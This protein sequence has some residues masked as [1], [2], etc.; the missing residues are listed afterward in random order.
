VAG[1][2][3]GHRLG[4]RGAAARQSQRDPDGH[5]TA[6]V[7]GD[8]GAVGAPHGAVF[9][10]AGWPA[11]ASTG[12]SASTTSAAAMGPLVLDPIPSPIV[13]GGTKT[14]SGT[15][16]TPASVIIAF[17]Q[18]G[19]GVQSLGPY[20]PTSETPTQ[21][22]WDVSPSIPLGQGFIVLAIVNPDEGY[23]GSGFQSQRLYGDPAHNIPTILSIN[24]NAIQGPDAA[25]NGIYVNATV[26]AGNWV[27]LGGTGFNNPAVNFFT[28]SG[29]LGPLPVR[30]VTANQFEAQIPANAPLGLAGFEVVNSP[31]NGNVGSQVVYASLGGP[32]TITGVTQ[33]GATVT[34]AG[35][36][37]APAP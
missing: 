8:A 11:P 17:V 34:I 1:S 37:F 18:T 26:V 16:F 36:G 10:P 3:R 2:R 30:N 20:T 9:D 12:S 33:N 7:G 15:G 24:G 4:A 25:L 19:S 29:N 13:V 27:T 28:A 6:A 5:A 21:L 14:L 32:P 23:R 31:Y 35:T 22:V